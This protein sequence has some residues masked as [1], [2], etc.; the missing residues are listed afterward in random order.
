MSPR[1]AVST[2]DG[3]I[4]ILLCFECG[5]AQIITRCGTGMVPINRSARPLFEALIRK[6]G[7]KA[8]SSH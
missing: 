1:H 8:D 7:L 6:Y 2:P 4:T 5:Q 3:K